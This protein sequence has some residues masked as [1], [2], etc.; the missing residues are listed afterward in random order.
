MKFLISPSPIIR[1]ISIRDALIIISTVAY[2]Y[3]VYQY[4]I[5]MC[6]KLLADPAVIHVQ[7]VRTPYVRIIQTLRLALKLKFN[8]WDTSNF[9]FR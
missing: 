3:F 5:S 7:V 9:N 2:Q 8:L 4:Q 6:I 1:R